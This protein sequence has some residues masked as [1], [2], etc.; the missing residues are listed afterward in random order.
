MSFPI[1]TV[2]VTAV[3]AGFVQGT[4]G[5]AQGIILMLVLPGI[6]GVL[7][8][9]A[10]SQ[11][12]SFFVCITL[13][14]IYRRHIS[15]K[16]CIRVWILYFPLFFMIH[17]W[18][19]NADAS[20]LRPL[21]GIVLIIISL[22]GIFFAKKIK[23]RPTW[24]TILICTALTAALD[25]FFG[26]GGPPMVILMLASTKSHE[27][28]LGTLQATFACCNLGA[29]L[30]RI[31][32]GQFPA[33]L[34]SAMGVLMPALIAGILLARP[35]VRHITKEKSIPFVYA[36]IGLAGLATFLKCVL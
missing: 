15:R 16:L 23:I 18:G 28:Y 7:N 9:G 22:F 17:C 25:V 21:L 6:F 8:A 34:F 36:T 10:L 31:S 24:K 11:F 4:A 5:F 27:E 13:A 26:I 35:A 3:I 30:I 32:T 2:A 14:V 20:V 1:I 29:T 19:K 33:E 12:A